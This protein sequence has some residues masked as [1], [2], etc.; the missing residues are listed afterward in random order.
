[1]TLEDIAK[2]MADPAFA[3]G[4]NKI[5]APSLAYLEYQL[6][7]ACCHTNTNNKVWTHVI[8]TDHQQAANQPHKQPTNKN[9]K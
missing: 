7:V 2:M 1:M 8:Y 3:E 5:L 4:I 6:P 9:T